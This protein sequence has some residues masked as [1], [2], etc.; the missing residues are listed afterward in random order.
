MISSFA[1]HYEVQSY[2]IAWDYRSDAYCIP[3]CTSVL[4]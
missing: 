3:L 1:F 4:S 2:A